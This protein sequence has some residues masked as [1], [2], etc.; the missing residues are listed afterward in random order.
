[1]NPWAYATQAPQSQATLD[2]TG[3]AYWWNPWTVDQGAASRGAVNSAQFADHTNVSQYEVWQQHYY[4]SVTPSEILAATVWDGPAYTP[5]PA[6]HHEDQVGGI[7][8]Q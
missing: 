2:W 1:M 5:F 8:F 3:R 6:V 4:Q 7:P